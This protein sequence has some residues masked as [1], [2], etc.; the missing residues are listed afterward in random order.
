MFK[1]HYHVI[2]CGDGSVSVHFHQTEQQAKDADKK[3]DEGWGESSA[4][5]IDLKIENGQ[6]Y[7]KEYVCINEEESDYEYKWFPL[8][9]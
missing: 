1:L 2:N 3:M 6:I 4:N 5:Y 7:F 9:K 8:I